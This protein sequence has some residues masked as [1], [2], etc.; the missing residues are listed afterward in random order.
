MK[1]ENEARDEA[2]EKAFSAERGAR[3]TAQAVPSLRA[4]GVGQDVRDCLIDWIDNL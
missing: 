2:E 1:R 3:S 4:R